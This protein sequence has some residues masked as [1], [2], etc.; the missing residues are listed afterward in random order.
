M[1]SINLSSSHGGQSLV[2]SM[3][4][5]STWSWRRPLITAW[6]AALPLTHCVV[7]INRAHY[8]WSNQCYAVFRRWWLNFKC[9]LMT[10]CCE[11]C[12]EETFSGFTVWIGLLLQAVLG[13][14]YV[15]SLPPTIHFNLLLILWVTITRES[16]LSHCCLSEWTAMIVT[17]LAQYNFCK[18]FFLL[19]ITIVSHLPWPPKSFDLSTKWICML[20][21]SF[22]RCR[23]KETKMT[24]YIWLDFLLNVWECTMLLSGFPFGQ[25]PKDWQVVHIPFS[26]G[27]LIAEW[28]KKTALSQRAVLFLW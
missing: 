16:S 2:K 27:S 9:V 25:R 13:K 26:C 1:P 3:H 22:K 20:A 7:W 18:M 21:L 23:K 6:R 12:S 10:A 28:P 24:F 17:L 4:F 19:L 15:F 11:V 8:F 14:T 5:I